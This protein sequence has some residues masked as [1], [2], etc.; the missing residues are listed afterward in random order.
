MVN[1]TAIALVSLR[2]MQSHDGY[3]NPWTDQ[4]GW[5]LRCNLPLLNF[6]E[7]SQDRVDIFK[8]FI[9]LVPDLHL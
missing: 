3:E 4:Q 6:P 1:I 9:N 5:Q 2:N 8:G 7:F